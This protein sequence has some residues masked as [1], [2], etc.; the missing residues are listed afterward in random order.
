MRPVILMTRPA[1][2]GASTAAELAAMTGCDVVQ[3]PVLDLRGADALPPME[4]VAGVILTSRNAARVYGDLGGPERPA[5]CVG[6]A[7]AR[8][9]RAAGLHAEVRGGDAEALVQALLTDPV[10]GR[11]VHLR[12]RRARGDVAARLNA[13]GQDVTEA[14]IY[15]QVPLPL[16]NAARDVL[17]GD[18]PVIVPLYSPR[19][20]KE[21]RRQADPDA[22]L[23]CIAMSV[24]VAAELD[25]MPG[26]DLIIAEAPDAAAMA[27][28]V[29]ATLQR[30]EGTGGAH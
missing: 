30:V 7:T 8:A 12:G 18:A 3:S 1:P 26:V 25:G 4:G 28:A 22:P 19:S 14:V 24:N 6:E 13:A 27:R 2:D 5:I 9:A 23:H 21:F 16:T 15:D 17:G 20:A 29:M 10:S 11:W